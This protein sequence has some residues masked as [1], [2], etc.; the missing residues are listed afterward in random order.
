MP[1]VSAEVLRALFAQG[2]DADV[3]AATLARDQP[4]PLHAFYRAQVCAKAFG[5][6]LASSEPSFVD[7]FRTIRTQLVPVDAKES[8]FNVN[9]EE[10]LKTIAR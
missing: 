10:D 9:T 3:I 5:P 8:F 6:L 4:E 2:R 1:S 7:L